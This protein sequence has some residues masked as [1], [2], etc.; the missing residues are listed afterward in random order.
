MQYTKPLATMLQIV[1][2]FAWTRLMSTMCDSKQ[3][4]IN[5]ETQLC[6]HYDI[7]KTPTIGIGYQLLQNNSKTVMS[8]Y[9][10]TLSQVL[11]DCHR[12]TSTYCLANDQAKDIFYR[13]SYPEAPRCV[14]E[15]VSN[16]PSTKRNA[17]IDV[18]FTSCRTLKTFNQMQKA[19]EVKDWIQ[20]AEE[21]K[22]SKWCKQVNQSQCDK[23]YNCI[24]NNES[25]D[26]EGF[27]TMEIKTLK[28]HECVCYQ[29]SS[30]IQFCAPKFQCSI[31]PDCHSCSTSSS[32]CIIDS[33]CARKVC[34][35]LSFSGVCNLNS[36]NQSSLFKRLM[37]TH[38]GRIT[39]LI[40]LFPLP[41]LLCLLLSIFFFCRNR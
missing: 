6:C 31:F 32:V 17:I 11:S 29:T 36:S 21:L 13:I 27:S 16:L 10:L 35:P 38:S 33:G 18:A 12:N 39:L 7:K 30:S 25:N 5:H 23:D 22:Y 19:L 37:S 9:N 2:L 4:M 14:D 28:K 24:R 1:L 3:T 15:Y 8:M 41:L 40:I 26:K 20:A 34:V